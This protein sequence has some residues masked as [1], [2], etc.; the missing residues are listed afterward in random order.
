MTKCLRLPLY[1]ITA[2]LL[3]L[4]AI[5][6]LSNPPSS[7][8]TQ[9]FG[10]HE[11]NYSLFPSTFLLPEVAATYELKRS[12]YE[13]LLNV[14]VSPKGKYGGLPIELNGYV[15]NLLQQ[16]KPLEF[17][18]IQEADTVYYLAPVRISGEELVHFTLEVKPEGE[19]QATTIKFTSKLYSDR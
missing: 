15:T 1:L 11:L 7:Q 4:L 8:G 13:S 14:S 2:C 6:A 16:Q 3:P 5:P 17:T 18:R 10:D 19:A 9:V 12:K